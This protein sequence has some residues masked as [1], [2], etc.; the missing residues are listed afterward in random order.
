MKS[1][2]KNETKT[3]Q[4][5]SSFERLSG[6]PRKKCDDKKKKR[7]EEDSFAVSKVQHREATGGILL[8]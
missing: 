2:S 3:K 8:D 7:G 5:K 6:E 4:T 1:E